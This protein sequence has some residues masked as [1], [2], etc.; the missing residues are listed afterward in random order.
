MRAIPTALVPLAAAVLYTLAPFPTTSQDPQPAKAP[1][2]APKADPADTASIEAITAALYDVISGPAGQ[3]RDWDRMRSL[4][5][6]DARLVPMQKGRDG[7]MRARVMTPEDYIRTSGPF[8]ETNGFFE[9]EI[10]RRVDAF[11]DVAHVFSTYEGR[12]AAGDAEPFLRGINS[13]QLVRQQDRWWVLQILWEQEHD[14]GPIPQRY[15]PGQE[16][17]RA[18][19]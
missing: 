14:A 4:F 2:A 3:A 19:K 1:A 16:R 18:G 8:L 12:K 13:I 17:E 9:Q 11:G 15:L 5:H 7:G 10:A 6:P